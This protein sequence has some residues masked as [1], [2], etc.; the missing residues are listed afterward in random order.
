MSNNYD[1]ILLKRI[2]RKDTAA[3]SEFY[4]IHSKYLYTIIYRILSHEAE[5]ENLL[6]EVFI[7]I[8]DKS[9]SY[10]ETLGNPMTWVTS[11]TRNKS[12]DKLRSQNFKKLKDE[13]NIEKVFHISEDS[14]SP[15]P[16]YNFG[17]NPQQILIHDSLKS[18]NDIQRNLLEFAYFRGYSQS[19]LAEHFHIPFASVKTIMRSSMMLLRDNLQILLVKDKNDIVGDIV[20]G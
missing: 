10:D 19:E 1:L 16:E 5:A 18:L 3:L 6:Q 12:I 13:N 4:D 17:F 20:N 2:I 7:Q 9:S 8:W 15:N 11:L 14:V